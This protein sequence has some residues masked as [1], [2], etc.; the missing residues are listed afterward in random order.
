MAT[1]KRASKKK[2]A[3]PA[4]RARTG[5]SGPGRTVGSTRDLAEGTAE[6]AEGLSAL[7]GQFSALDA[8]GYVRAVIVREGKR[9]GLKGTK[10]S[11]QQRRLVISG[12]A[13]SV[14]QLGRITGET[15]EIPDSKWCKLPSTRR[16]VANIVEALRPF[17]EA[18]RAVADVLEATG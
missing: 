7:V 1:L 18:A 5:K 15:L 3:R 6:A 2:A 14:E 9:L 11:E 4:R 10:M 12:L 17:P 8:A 13:K 16:M